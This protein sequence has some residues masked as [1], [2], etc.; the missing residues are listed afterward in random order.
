[1]ATSTIANA[2]KNQMLQCD[3]LFEDRSAGN[4]GIGKNQDEKT[5]YFMFTDLTGIAHS[6][7]FNK[8]VI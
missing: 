1:L 7:M 8:L 2:E 6:N 3:S 5:N 4:S